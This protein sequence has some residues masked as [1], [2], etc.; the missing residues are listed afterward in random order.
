M[1]YNK[2]EEEI[3]ELHTLS[4]NINIIYDRGELQNWKILY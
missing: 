4:I 3:I 1:F 2:P